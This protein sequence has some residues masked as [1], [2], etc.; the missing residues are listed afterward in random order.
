MKMQNLQL[1]SF[2]LRKL[3]SY[4]MEAKT[5]AYFIILSYMGIFGHSQTS[6]VI[7]CSLLAA[8]LAGDSDE[9]KQH[10]KAYGKD[11]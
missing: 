9:V 3:N 11:Q 8:E 7:E 10:I 6:T 5:R 2:L 1:L 4:N